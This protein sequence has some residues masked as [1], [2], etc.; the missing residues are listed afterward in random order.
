MQKA[1][2]AEFEDSEWCMLVHGETRGKAK[3]NFLHWNPGTD[4]PDGYEMIRLRRLPGLDGLPFTFG[5][6]ARAGFYYEGED[7]D[8]AD[9]DPHNFVNDCQCDVC[10]PP[11]DGKDSDERL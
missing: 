3:A 5:N 9:H 4:D 1:Y 2:V 6:C 7:G 11:A 10:N 8:P